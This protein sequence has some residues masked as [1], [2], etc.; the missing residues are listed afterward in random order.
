[1]D[2]YTDMEQ[3]EEIWR[4]VLK[5]DVSRRKIARETGMF[6]RMSAKTRLGDR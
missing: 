2:V 3:W 1:M 5:E 4:R 6:T